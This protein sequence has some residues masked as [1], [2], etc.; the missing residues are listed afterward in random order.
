MTKTAIL[1][2]IHGNLYILEKALAICKSK[3]VDRYV[4]LGDMISDGPDSQAV[5]DVISGLTDDVIRGNREEYILSYHQGLKS[6]WDGNYQCESL[7]MAYESLNAKGL[8]YISRLPNTKRIDLYGIDTLIVHGSH[9]NTRQLI[10]PSRNIDVFMDMYDQYD[11]ELFLLGHSHQSYFITLKD[12]Y[13]INPGPL[14]MPSSLEHYSRKDSFSFGILSIDQKQDTFEYEQ[15]YIPY[16][17]ETLKNYYL[18]DIDKYKHSFW[19]E[20]IADSF[21]TKRYHSIEFLHFAQDIAYE[22]GY[23]HIDPIP[24]DIWVKAAEKWKKEHIGS[25]LF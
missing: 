22:E 20:L 15:V 11:C 16:D 18:K 17:V 2:D 3:G 6:E 21:Y 12:K 1:S 13:F 19:I 8:E 7:V 14:G 24:N 5:L 9:L 23:G 4:V 10:L 25:G